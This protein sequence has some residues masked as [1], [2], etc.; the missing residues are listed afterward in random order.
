MK[1]YTS[2]VSPVETSLIR[3]EL[4]LL[5]KYEGPH[6][7]DGSYPNGALRACRTV[8]LKTPSSEF[9]EA[10]P[11]TKAFLEDLAESLTDNPKFGRIYY[12]T[13]P[14]MSRIDAHSDVGGYFSYIDRYQVFFDLD[15]EHRIFQTKA[16]IESNSLV[17]FNHELPHG[18]SNKSTID[19]T[20]LVFDLYKQGVDG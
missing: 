4:D 14:P 3:P 15:P 19:W 5:S 11:K 1:F 10:F 6:Y 9:H 8:W 2:V 18:F 16:K 17:K 20:F 12:T 7:I 13:L